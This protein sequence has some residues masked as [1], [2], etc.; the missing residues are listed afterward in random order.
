M[1]NKGIE[2]VAGVITFIS[3]WIAPDIHSAEDLVMFIVNIL[4]KICVGVFSYTCS[5]LFYFYYGD[6]IKDKIKDLKQQF[7]RSKK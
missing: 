6:K 2:I 1:S 3:T 4:F 5:K 7:N